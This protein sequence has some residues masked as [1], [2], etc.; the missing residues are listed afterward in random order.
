MSMTVCTPRC[1]P[2]AGSPLPGNNPPPAPGTGNGLPEGGN[3]GDIIVNTGPGQGEWQPNTGGGEPGPAG[4][5]AYEIAVEEGFIGTEAEWLES[6]VGPEGPEGPQGVP[7]TQGLPGADGAE[8][9]QGIPGNDGP[10]GIQGEDGPM[11]PQGNIGP[12]GPAL[13]IDEY[14]LLTEAKITAIETADVDWVFLVDPNGDD[15]ADQTQPP[16]L[17]G[18]ME[19]HLLFYRASDNSWQDYGVFTGIPGPEGPQGPQ[20]NPGAQGNQ[21]I[22]GI[23]GEA[24]PAGAQGNPGPAGDSAYQ[25]ALDN[26]FVGSEAAWLASLVGPEGPEGPQGDPGAT[27]PEGDPGPQGIPGTNGTTQPTHDVCILNETLVPAGTYPLTIYQPMA[28]TFTKMTHRT[29]Q[30]TV[31]NLR[32]RKNGAI[33]A[34]VASVTTTRVTTPISVAVV[35][36]DI[37]E[38]ELTTTT[39][40][41]RFDF[42]LS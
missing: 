39:G 9:P 25:V 33:V 17:N 26:G 31:G 40:V 21:G 29:A 41:R 3:I 23:Q 7:G 12:M 8:G 15:R 18:D 10:Q 4:K 42:S 11:G 36:G 20:G 13:A 34:T 24:G 5:S 6:L 2:N 35:E 28:Y 27:G 30:G 22:Q 38:I 37:L 1:G 16:S 19:R 32:L 14:G